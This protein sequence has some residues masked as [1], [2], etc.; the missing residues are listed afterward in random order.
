MSATGISV[1]D[2]DG[3]RTTTPGKPAMISGLHG[4]PV[5]ELNPGLWIRL[6]SKEKHLT[7]GVSPHGDKA[8]VGLVSQAQGNHRTDPKILA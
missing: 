4:S 3:P 8:V 5:K 2:S 7:R 1:C 6:V